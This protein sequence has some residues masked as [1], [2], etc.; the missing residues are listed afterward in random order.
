[1]ALTIVSTKYDDRARLP[2]RNTG[3]DPLF[4]PLNTIN[5]IGARPGETK[6][7]TA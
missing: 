4:R 7:D 1:M 2:I 6:H 3:G 5:L